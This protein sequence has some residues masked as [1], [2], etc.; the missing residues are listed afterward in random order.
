MMDKPMS[1]EV[2]ADYERGFE[3]EGELR[4]T[5]A[6]REIRQL[7]KLLAAA[8]GALRQEQ[9]ERMQQTLDED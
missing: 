7:R 4:G 1:D 9:W 6:C 8:E 5:H 3:A 2:L